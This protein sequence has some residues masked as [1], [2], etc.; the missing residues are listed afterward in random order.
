MSRPI[1]N[2][3]DRENPEFK[4]PFQIRKV[5]GL[6]NYRSEFIHRYIENITNRNEPRFLEEVVQDS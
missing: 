5:C 3:S 2:T 6:P 4:D 1:K